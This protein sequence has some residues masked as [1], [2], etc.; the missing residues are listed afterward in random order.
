MITHD[1]VC[2]EDG[3][4]HVVNG[5]Q[6]A[7]FPACHM[8]VSAA[9]A[10]VEEDVRKGE[11]ASLRFQGIDGILRPLAAHSTASKEN[12]PGCGLSDDQI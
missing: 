12:F 3:W 1:V 4:V 5:I 11:L 10:E 7:S 2:A 9:R 8:A 6:V